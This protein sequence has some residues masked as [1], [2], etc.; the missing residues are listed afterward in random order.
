MLREGTDI[1]KNAANQLD[2]SQIARSTEGFL[3]S[4]LKI[5]I[6]K[7]VDAAIMRCI[8]TNQADINLLQTDFDKV[9]KDF[10]PSSLRGIKLQKSTV[11]WNDIGGK[12]FYFHMLTLL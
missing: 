11:Q 7:S 2:L 10:V 12:I 6:E 4:D 1:L 5:L 8:H 3:S 9:L